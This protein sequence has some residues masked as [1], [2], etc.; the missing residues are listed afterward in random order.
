ILE[1]AH[2]IDAST[3]EFLDLCLDQIASVPVLMLIT[4]RPPFEYGFGGHPIVS[5]LALN[6]LG[7]DQVTAIVDKITGGKVLPAELLEEIAT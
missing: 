2:W 7:R 5:T 6:R 4:A 3:L 1:D